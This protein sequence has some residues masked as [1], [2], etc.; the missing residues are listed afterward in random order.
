MLLS[1]WRANPKS[2]ILAT[3][4][5]NSILAGLISL[6]IIF[7]GYNSRNASHIYRNIKKASLSDNFTPYNK[8]LL[9]IKNNLNYVFI[10]LF[11]L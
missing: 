8:L 6:C 4:L 10:P 9:K 7:L 2:L 11:L 5:F 3:P 1:I